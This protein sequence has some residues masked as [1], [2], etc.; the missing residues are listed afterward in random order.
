MSGKT[1]YD[2]IA[3]LLSLAYSY[4]TGKLTLIHSLG[5]DHFD[6]TSNLVCQ[7]WRLGWNVHRAQGEFKAAVSVVRWTFVYLDIFD[8]S[9]ERSGVLDFLL[10]DPRRVQEEEISPR[11]LCRGF[12]VMT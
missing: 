9:R 8:I 3:H 1:P 7:A 5:Q 6:L 4:V 11:M 12:L 2:E 10:M